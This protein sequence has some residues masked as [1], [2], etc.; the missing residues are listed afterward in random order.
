SLRLR[1]NPVLTFKTGYDNRRTIRL[2]RD[3]V[4]PET[5]FDDDFRQGL[6]WGADLRIRKRYRMGFDLRTRSGGSVSRANTYTLNLGASRLTSLGFR[7]RTRSSRYTNQRVEGWLHSLTTGFSMGARMN[8]DLNGGMRDENSLLP[9]GQQS[10]LTWYGFDWD[11]N[12]G[13]HWFLLLSTERDRSSDA[14]RAN[15]QYYTTLVYRF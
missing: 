3:F 1:V 13:R 4:T 7:I 2:Y 9:G 15:D 12:I 14:A 6:W 8:L 5:Q 11:I 10:K